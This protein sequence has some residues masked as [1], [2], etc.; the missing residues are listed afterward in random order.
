MLNLQVVILFNSI[1]PKEVNPLT[2]L[3]RLCGI[4]LENPKIFSP[5]NLFPGPKAAQT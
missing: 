4:I 1:F 2:A 3:G 5:G